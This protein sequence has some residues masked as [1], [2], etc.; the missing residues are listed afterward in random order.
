ML[1]LAWFGQV[2]DARVWTHEDIAWM[3]V[4]VKEVLLG[5]TDVDAPKRRLWEGVGRDECKAVKANLVDTVDGLENKNIQ[6]I[7]NCY[8]MILHKKGADSC[9]RHLSFNGFKNVILVEIR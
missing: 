5:F 8:I 1:F 4:S 7:Q 6:C 2:G 9:L 3:Q